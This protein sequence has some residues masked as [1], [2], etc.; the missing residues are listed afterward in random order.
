MTSL[1]IGII[2]AGP[3]GLAALKTIL[4]SDEYTRGQ[5][6]PTVFEASST[7]GGVWHPS[8]SSPLYD[9][10]TTNLPHPIMAFSSFPFPPSTLLFPPA[11]TVQTY[12]EAYAD[13][14]TL[15]PHI[16]FNTRVAAVEWR[17]PHWHVRVDDDAKSYTFSLL[18]VCNGHHNTPRM[19]SVPGLDAWLSP[20]PA[21]PL[22]RAS[23]SITYR[24]PSSLVL[25]LPLAQ[26]SILVI[27]GGPSGLDISDELLPLAKRVFLSTSTGAPPTPPSKCIIKPR[28]TLFSSSSS[29]SASTVHFAD[30]T[31]EHIDYCILATGYAV[32]FP[33]FPSSS[34]TNDSGQ[35]FSLSS[36]LIPST[37]PLPLPTH[38]LTNTSYAL[39]P[40]ARH[41]FGLPE[42]GFAP[43]TSNPNPELHI[44][45]PPTSIAFPG[46][47]VR[48]APLPVVEAQAR[49]ALAVFR[50]ASTPNSNANA[51]LAGN[52]AITDTQPHHPQIDWQH[53][54]YLIQ[55][56]HAV[57][58]AKFHD[59]LPKSPSPCQSQSPI[60]PSMTT[61]TDTNISN[62]PISH[63]NTLALQNFLSHEWDHFDPLEQFAYRDALDDLVA[64]LSLSPSPPPP[65]P[66][67]HTH[68]STSTRTRP[69][70][71]RIHIHTLAL[72]RA[73]R[74]L[75]ARG[76][77]DAWVRGVGSGES[78]KTAEE[79]WVDLMW[80][81]LEW[82][83]GQVD[84]EEGGEGGQGG[85]SLE[86]A[87]QI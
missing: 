30:G 13:A 71:P 78:G 14:F 51:Y 42:C 44:L 85:K 34:T 27:G 2:G 60:Q 49:A 12:I 31:T 47:L 26:S 64:S 37:S 1:R 56:R 55:T 11:H 65:P 75:E 9:S 73:W 35:D 83:E 32:S 50:A 17:H 70:E 7:V 48:V 39:F 41:L 61:N 25:P 69:W 8:A 45:P 20:S 4:D 10:L 67:T 76:E 29:T 54:S 16:R 68:T 38:S 57:L 81:V 24:N 59:S 77:A 3:A 62:T 80:R 22:P 84:D 74:L 6:A 66:P 86:G 36:S 15:R 79:E 53:E 43:S 87:V 46:L 82:G 19:P 28:T 52:T 58:T 5:W 63:E 72:R 23:H 40:L 18:L 33:F 21:H